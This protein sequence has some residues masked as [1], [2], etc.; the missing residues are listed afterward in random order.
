M[1]RGPSSLPQLVCES[2]V[3]GISLAPASSAM[4]TLDRQLGARKG[5]GLVLASALAGVAD[6]YDHAIVDCPPTLGVLMINALA[7]G[8]RL[9]LPVQTEHLAIKG[10]ERML[11]TLDMVNR[12]RKDSL[13]PL[14]IPCMFDRRTRAAIQSLD[15][16]RESY[17]DTIWDSVIPVDTQFREASKLGVP[18][19]HTVP[20]SRGAQAYLQLLEHLMEAPADRTE[21]RAKE[22]S[23]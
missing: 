13:N 3:D 10:L 20:S 22:A 15:Y 21:L 19:S 4:A 8:D 5:Q 18:I 14:I 1:E 12:S 2:G 7:A 16:L 9:L 17:A 23:A 11:R 6:R